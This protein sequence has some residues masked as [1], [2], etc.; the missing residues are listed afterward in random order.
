MLTVKNLTAKHAVGIRAVNGVSFNLAPGECMALIGANGAGKTSLL[1][2]ILGLLPLISGEISADGLVL[3][4]KTLAEFRKKTGLVFQNPDDQLF[5]STV[6]E[7]A[8]F[9]SRN[10]GLSETETE[11]RVSAALSELGIAHLANR[12]PLRLSGGEKRLAAIAA[13]LTVQPDYLLFDEP[14]AFLDPKARRNLREIIKGLPQGKLIATHDLPFA[15]EC[16]TRVLILKDGA[17]AAGG[18]AE[19]LQDA[20][21]LE[22]W[23]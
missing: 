9:G 11:K 16:C 15:A 2:A 1:S 21:A 14:T 4:K 7:D 23:G 10:S 20:A 12:S 19:L 17:V 22:A 8:A 13:V 5:M 6:F 3:G 18:G